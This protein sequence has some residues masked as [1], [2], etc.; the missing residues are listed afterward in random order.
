MNLC[1]EQFGLRNHSIRK[2]ISLF[3]L[4]Q[5]KSWSD[6]LKAAWSNCNLWLNQLIKWYFAIK[7]LESLNC[8]FIKVVILSHQDLKEIQKKYKTQTWRLYRNKFRNC[9]WHLWYIFIISM[10]FTYIC[11]YLLKENVWGRNN[12]I[13]IKER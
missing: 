6:A 3:N 1:V 2:A 12:K 5:F 10:S 4:N 9:Y 8:H 13:E 7:T 11:K